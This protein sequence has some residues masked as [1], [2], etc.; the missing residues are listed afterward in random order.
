[1]VFTKA[2]ALWQLVTRF[3]SVLAYDVGRNA[4]LDDYIK[5][6]IA[7]KK[8]YEEVLTDTHILALQS[9]EL[10]TLEAMKKTLDGMG[11]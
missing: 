9:G 4:K 7:L 8:A 6:C 1:M 2:R 10:A 5:M 3:E 11:N